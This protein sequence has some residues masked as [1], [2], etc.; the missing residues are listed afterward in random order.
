MSLG[1]G[2]GGGE[3]EQIQQQLQAIEQEIGAVEEEIEE[4]EAEQSE[5]DEAI[6]AVERLDSGDIVQVPLGGG[7]YVR[8]EVQDI[9]E[10]VVGLGGGY[11]AERDQEGAVESLEKQKD[12]LDD[13]IEDLEEDISDLE[14]ESE[15][16]EERARE[17]QQQQMQMMQQ[18]MQG[19]GQPGPGGESDETRYSVFQLKLKRPFGVSVLDGSPVFTTPHRASLPCS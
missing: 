3:M 6:E 18:Q 17:M 8:A 19:Q 10:I 4:L 16:V 9:D 7:A 1:G 13:R 11:A 15:E 12:V 2:G 5:I 14:D